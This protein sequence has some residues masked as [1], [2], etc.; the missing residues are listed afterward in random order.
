MPKDRLPNYPIEFIHP[1]IL[2]DGTLI[3]LRPIHPRDGKHAANFKSRI[4]P[5]SIYNRFL[6]YLPP[7]SK[8]VIERF[9]EVD[10]EREIAIVAEHGELEKEPI[11]VA[12]LASLEGS[13]AEFAI[14]I[15]DDWQRKGL[16]SILIKYMI[17]VAVKMNFDSIYASYFSDNVGIKKLLYRNGFR[18]RSQDGGTVSVELPLDMEDVDFEV[19]IEF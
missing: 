6:G 9:T 8:E 16:G 7:L 3:Q 18:K 15:A 5:E 1:A 4:S 2:R 14:V 11:A 12:R 17:R 10:Y 19:D 13:R